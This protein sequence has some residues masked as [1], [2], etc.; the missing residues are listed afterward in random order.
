MVVGTVQV[1]QK[2]RVLPIVADSSNETAAEYIGAFKGIEL[3]WATVFY[4]D[5]F[6]VGA[7]HLRD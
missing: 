4:F 1:E 3:D 7:S 6:S 5:C 2:I